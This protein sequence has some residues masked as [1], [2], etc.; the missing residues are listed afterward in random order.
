MYAPPPTLARRV[1]RLGSR[2]AALSF[3]GWLGIVIG[4]WSFENFLVY[5][6]TAYQ[7]GSP[8]WQPR[9]LIYEDVEIASTDGAQLHGWFAPV[10]S[11]R[12]VLLLLHGNGGNISGLADE[13]RILQRKMGVAALAVDYRGYGKSTGAP[14]EQ[15]ILDDARA[16]RAW[17]AQRTGVRKQDVVLW[18]FSMGGG[19][20]VDL[21]AEEGARGLVLQSTFTSLP[22]AAAEHYPW[23]P[24]RWL[25]R[26]RL[27]SASKIARYRGPLLQSHGTADAIVPIHLG[28]QL[29]ALANDPKRFVEIPDGDHN[30]LPDELFFT[31]LDEFIESLP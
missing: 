17:L 6:P 30:D 22:D 31:A 7:S 16:A 27:D 15:G 5:Q 13:L 25:M 11:P 14:S 18:G 28:R 3:V 19:V 29:H 21:A 24:V 4:M 2:C 9:E 26:N 23:L 8:Y 12:A 10:E 20:A 1:S